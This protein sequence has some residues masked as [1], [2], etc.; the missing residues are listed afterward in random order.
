MKNFIS[1]LIFSLF[2]LLMLKWFFISWLYN[3]SFGSLIV[4]DIIALVSWF[5]D[6]DKSIYV[7]RLLFYMVGLIVFFSIV[8]LSVYLLTRSVDLNKIK[9]LFLYQI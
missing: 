4:S 6:L 7:Y 9:R 2:S 8:S 3:L 1:K 5:W